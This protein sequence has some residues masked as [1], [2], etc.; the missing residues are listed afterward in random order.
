MIRRRRPRPAPPVGPEPTPVHRDRL[1]EWLTTIDQVV[2]LETDLTGLWSGNQFW[3][4]LLGP[5][6]DIVQVRG[7]W[8]RTLHMSLARPTLMA[9]NDWNRE[10]VWPKAYVRAEDERLA[11]Y[12]EISVDLGAGATDAQLHQI[13]DSGVESGLGLFRV[14]DRQLPPDPS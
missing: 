6:N 4:M 13:L 14:L 9:L 1:V 11:I 3:F 7:R 8:M 12:A 2:S 5:A 10:R